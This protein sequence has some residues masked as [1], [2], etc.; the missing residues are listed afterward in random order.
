M[1]TQM[2]HFICLF[3]AA[4]LFVPTSSLGKGKGRS[5]A[6]SKKSTA[7]GSKDGK[8]KGGRGSSHKGGSYSNKKTDGDYRNRKAGT[9]K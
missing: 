2:K 1:H 7:S 4:V 3:L 9:P 6:G 5:S 8:Y